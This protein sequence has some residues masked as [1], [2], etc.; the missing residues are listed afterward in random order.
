MNQKIKNMNSDQSISKKLLQVNQSQKVFPK[1]ESRP[2]KAAEHSDTNQK[3]NI[4]ET[5][6]TLST[7]KLHQ[8]INSVQMN[9]SS[10]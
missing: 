1:S 3:Q 2:K 4:N 8:T 9:N 6:Q 5:I 7:I 10:S